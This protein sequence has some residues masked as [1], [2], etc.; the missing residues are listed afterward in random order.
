MAMPAQTDILHNDDTIIS[1]SL[2]VGNDC[3]NG[4][5]FGFDTVRLKEN[6]LRIHFDD[7]SNSASFPSNDWRIIINDTNNGGAS[8]FS[9]EDATAGRRPF[10]IEAGAAANSLYVENDGDVGLGTSNP[11]VELHVVDGDSPTIR[12]EQNGSSGFTPQT[13][14]IASNEANFFIRDVTNSSQLF[15]R[16]KPGAPENS[17][18]I[19]SEGDIGLGT[20]APA[21]DLHI[22]GQQVRLENSGPIAAFRLDESGST[23]GAGLQLQ[24]NNLFL[25]FDDSTMPEFRIDT[26]GNVTLEGSI[27]TAG[28]TCGSGCDAVFDPNYDLQTIQEHAEEMFSKK[29][30]PNVGPTEENKPINLTD[31]L[32]RMLNELEKAHIYIAQLNDE[33]RALQSRVEAQEARLEK[34]ERLVTQ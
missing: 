18:F 30:L 8:Y 34:L 24:S 33:K 26:G 7:T 5:N 9:I 14:D 16:S 20:D 10:T 23:F 21:A 11:V 19:D 28:G 13:Y 6:N 22:K 25:A 15:F 12:L 2:C 4:E 32:G 1:F 27:T 29:F 3:V 17:L 31:K